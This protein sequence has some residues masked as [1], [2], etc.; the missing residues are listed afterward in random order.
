MKLSHSSIS[1]YSDCPKKYEFKYV[2]RMPEKPKHF[3][4]FGKS[5]HSA[6]EF[7]Y[8]GEVCPP[9]DD[10]LEYLE[11]HWVDEGYADTKA[12]DKAKRNA[13]SMLR[14]YYRKHAQDWVKPLSVEAKFDMTV[15]HVRVTGFIDRVDMFPSG[16]LHVIDYKTGQSLDVTRIDDDEQMTMYQLAAKT[17]YPESEVDTV[18]LYHV[19]SLT[20][21]SAKART[22]D[23]VNALRDK[24]KRTADAIARKE[25][26]ATPSEK[27]C[28]WCDFKPHCSAWL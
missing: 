27:S 17:I 20:L 13:D 11:T 21:H 14:D 7:M 28:S 16:D 5:V 8:A 26:Q 4:S 6:L 19:P 10:V 15:D 23:K 12:Q 2:L 3:F 18:S 24:I 9:L 1:T 25:F 22:E